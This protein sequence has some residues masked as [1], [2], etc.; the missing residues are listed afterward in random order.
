MASPAPPVR[1]QRRR[2]APRRGAIRQFELRKGRKER[3]S[4]L[5]PAKIDGE[6]LAVEGRCISTDEVV[7]AQFG[8]E[9]AEHLEKHLSEAKLGH[10]QVQPHWKSG[11]IET[12]SGNAAVRHNSEMGAVGAPWKR[13]C[14]CEAGYV[15]SPLPQVPP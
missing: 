8:S 15:A 4:I 14:R 10:E 11:L 1:E 6:D 2:V 3:R 7:L 5:R 12:R 13:P 9:P